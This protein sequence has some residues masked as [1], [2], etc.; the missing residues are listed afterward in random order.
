MHLPLSEVRAALSSWLMPVL[1]SPA[2]VAWVEQWVGGLPD[3]FQNVA[4]ECRLGQTL[5]RMDVLACATR[6][7]G[8]EP[9]SAFLAERRASSRPLSPAWER[10]SALCEE[11]SDPASPLH[12]QLPLI[13]LEFDNP[14]EHRSAP[15][16]PFTF[17]C[18][19]PDYVDRPLVRAPPDTSWRL[20]ERGLA[21]LL[22]RPLSPG[23]AARV[24]SCFE[25][26]PSR[27]YVL[28]AA[29][30]ESRGQ[31]A[32]RLV[33][34]FPAAEI[35]GYLERIGWPGPRDELAALLDAAC[36]GFDTVGFSLDIGE[37]VQPV[38]G[39]ECYWFGADPRFLPLFE[40]LIQR[41]ACT[42][43]KRDAAMAWPGRERRVL[44]GDQWPSTLDR[45]LQL[46][47]VYRPG[48]PLEAKAYLGLSCRFSLFD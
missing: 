28:H 30:L 11:W 42:P 14:P 44:P 6:A 24:R 18:V 46:K 26:L 27:G 25:A 13:W 40:L 17:L 16:D 20:V 2:E 15:P 23:L 3:T 41:G 32:V 7:E 10:L 47:L 39:M 29:S 9:L 48:T 12:E 19:Q 5:S 43:E 34:T 31:D 35:P 36:I 4:F 1:S 38:F 45:M 33:L 37:R 22:G 8:R 21:P